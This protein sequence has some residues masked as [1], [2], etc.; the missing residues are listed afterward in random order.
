MLNFYSGACVARGR[1]QQL[2]LGPSDYWHSQR[3]LH[4]P[5]NGE[6]TQTFSVLSLSSALWES[7]QKQFYDQGLLTLTSCQERERR[8]SK[9]SVARAPTH[10]QWGNTH[11]PWKTFHS[12]LFDFMLKTELLTFFSS[13]TFWHGKVHACVSGAVKMHCGKCRRSGKLR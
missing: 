10:M 12:N 4:L 5:R 2:A 13:E 11:E 6:A 1:G 8:G 7:D 3:S 9:W